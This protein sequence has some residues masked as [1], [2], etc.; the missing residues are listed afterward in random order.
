MHSTSYIVRFVLIMTA[1][2]AV[3][4]AFLS[5]ALKPIH[6]QNEAVYNKRAVLKAVQVDLGSKV[7]DLSDKEVLDVFTNQISQKVFDMSGKELTKEEVESK[8]YKGG[9]AENVDMAQEKKKPEA[10]RIL[11][12]YIFKMKDGKNRIIVSVRGSGLWDEIWGSIALEEDLNTISGAAFDHKGETPGLGAEITDNAMFPKAFEGKKLYDADGTYKS[13][14]VV[15]GGLSDPTHQVDAISGATITTVGVG[16]M[17]VRGMKYY[18]PAFAS[19][20][21]AN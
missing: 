4:L 17:M 10:Q 2:V 18:E 15:K 12:M 11:P 16:E 5:T 13:V 21:K 20:K 9:L 6:S 1:I 3:I 19:L 8:G 14:D 7:S